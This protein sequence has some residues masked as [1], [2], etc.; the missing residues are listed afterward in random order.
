MYTHL[1]LNVIGLSYSVAACC[2][3]G[4]SFKLKWKKK[5]KQKNQTS[6]LFLEKKFQEKRILLILYVIQCEACLIK[7]QF[8]KINNG[9]KTRESRDGGSLVSLLIEIKSVLCP[10]GRFFSGCFIERRQMLRSCTVGDGWV[11]EHGALVEWYWQRET[12][13]IWENGA[14]IVPPIRKR[15]RYRSAYQKSHMDSP[16]ISAGHP[17]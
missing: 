3:I 7:H 17:R 9:D 11:I 6:N 2:Y 1:F 16:G 13:V 5:N 15:C 4:F 14:G 12:E 8:S 10:V